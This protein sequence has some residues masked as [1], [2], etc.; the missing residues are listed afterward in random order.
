MC[1]WIYIYFLDTDIDNKLKK[2]YE[3]TMPDL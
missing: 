1:Q 3:K 2:S